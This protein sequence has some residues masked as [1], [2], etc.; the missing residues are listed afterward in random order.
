MESVCWSLRRGPLRGRHHAEDVSAR[1]P[2]RSVGSGMEESQV[3]T[4]TSL[5][6]DVQAGGHHLHFRL[7]DHSQGR[8]RYCAAHAS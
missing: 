5:T 3:S 7:R 4:L 6:L 1:V 8:P 2:A